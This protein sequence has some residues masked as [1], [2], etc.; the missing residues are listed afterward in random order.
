MKQFVVAAALSAA[1]HLTLRAK[2][3]VKAHRL[4]C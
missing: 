2:A 4:R 3:C 1:L